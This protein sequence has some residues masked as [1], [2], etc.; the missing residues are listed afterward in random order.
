MRHARRLRL[1]RWAVAHFT[2]FPA[3]VGA[4]SGLEEGDK[5]SKHGY[6]AFIT[7]G[8]SYCETCTFSMKY[9]VSPK[10][11]LGTPLCCA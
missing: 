7:V 5:S 10:Q 3:A 6:Y 1:G 9:S 2:A 11:E 4:A 8:W